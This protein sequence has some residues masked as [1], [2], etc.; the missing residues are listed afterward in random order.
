MW[1]DFPAF[2]S[3]SVDGRGASHTSRS[4]T[5]QSWPIAVASG[6]LVKGDSVVCLFA[7][8]I[9]IMNQRDVSLVI[10]VDFANLG[11]AS[12]VEPLEETDAR[13]VLSH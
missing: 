3:T 9:N 12:K 7:Q 4:R 10:K 8:P 11:P 5:N 13:C 1:C 2:F 6:T